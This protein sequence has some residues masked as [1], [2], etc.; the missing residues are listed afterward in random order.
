MTKRI[1]TGVEVFFYQMPTGDVYALATEYDRGRVVDAE[2]YDVLT[3][4]EDEV[5]ELVDVGGVDTDT[6]APKVRSKWVKENGAEI[7]LSVIQDDGVEMQWCK[8]DIPC[9]RKAFG[10]C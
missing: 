9:I 10:K 4:T 3:M 2:R 1:F 8:T 5:K 7:A 6:P